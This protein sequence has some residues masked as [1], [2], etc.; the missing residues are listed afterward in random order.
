MIA[1][2]LCVLAFAALQGCEAQGLSLADI[3]TVADGA[4]A[5]GHVIDNLD[6]PVPT[7]SLQGSRPY[8]KLPLSNSSPGSLNGPIKAGPG[9]FFYDQHG[10]VVIMRGL[11]VLPSA[12]VPDFEPIKDL[13]T[14]DTI[15]PY[16]VNAVRLLF[17]W[18][19]W[20]TSPNVYDAS[21]LAYYE[22]VLN[23]LWQQLGIKSIVDVHQDGLSRYLL[24]G[25]GDGFPRWWLLKAINESQLSTP[26]N[27]NDCLIWPLYETQQARN[28]ASPFFTVY[29]AFYTN[30]AGMKSDYFRLWDKLSAHFAANPGV[31]GFDLF[32]EPLQLPPQYSIIQVY[33][34]LAPTIR[35]NA[36]ASLIFSSP[37][38]ITGFGN[39]SDFPKDV[40]TYNNTAYAGHYYPNQAFGSTAQRICGEAM[41]N[42]EMTA[43]QNAAADQWDAPWFVGE[44]GI[45]PSVCIGQ[46]TRTTAQTY[47]QNVYTAM[48][49]LLLSGTQ[50]DWAYWTKAKKDGF[51]GINLS[52][53]DQN[54][55]LRSN[56][57]VWPYVQAFGGVPASMHVDPVLLTF[58]AS[59]EVT[60]TIFALGGSAIQTEI[61]VP[62]PFFN[63]ASWQGVKIEASQGLTCAGG[64]NLITVTCVP[65]QPGSYNVKISA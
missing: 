20:E 53:V 24:K 57:A 33:D 28:P 3:S 54:F 18:E 52:I 61:F 5:L 51:D 60:P 37:N 23:Y 64:D 32:N 63:A 29:N 62:L 58:T 14:L 22:G 13:S 17:I 35:K 36:P 40:P 42:Q 6:Q 16:G 56:Y 65:T 21:Y 50:W 27:G 15:K 47:I 44:Y 34:E 7:I 25:C 41:V 59:W 12:K 2:L 9:K 55:N 38:V 30:H 39:I 26:D 4:E 8:K 10:R 45:S 19:A 46:D 1:G 48:N 31:L 11:N 49:A 43:F